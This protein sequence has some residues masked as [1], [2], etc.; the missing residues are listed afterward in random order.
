MPTLAIARPSAAQVQPADLP[1]LPPCVVSRPALLQRLL[2]S[3]SRL[4]LLCAP[5]GTGKSVLLGQCA[6]V[7]Y[8]HL[9]VYKRQHLRRA[10]AGTLVQAR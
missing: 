10:T 3:E 6:P 5:A 7:S 4:R 9:D 1:R 2:A 8:T